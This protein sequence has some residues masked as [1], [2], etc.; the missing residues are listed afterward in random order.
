MEDRSDADA[1]RRTFLLLLAIGLVTLVC[2]SLFSG[3]MPPYRRL[4]MR[5]SLDNAL[6]FLAFAMLATVTPPA[7]RTRAVAVGALFALL[8]MGFSLEFWQTF[9]PNRRCSLADASANM[10]GL[11]LGGLLGFV[12]RLRLLEPLMNDAHRA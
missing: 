1:V 11:T 8:L 2:V 6:H 10:L 9:I 7:F 3:F 12:L 5:V 4:F